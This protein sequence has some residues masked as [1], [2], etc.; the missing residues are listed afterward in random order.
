MLNKSN[1]LGRTARARGLMHQ[2]LPL[3]TQLSVHVTACDFEAEVLA[4]KVIV[5]TLLSWTCVSAA[6]DME[7]YKGYMGLLRNSGLSTFISIC[8][9]LTLNF[10]LSSR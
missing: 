7:S 5:K 2:H 1:D 3:F 6:F 9:K 8:S 4:C 10:S